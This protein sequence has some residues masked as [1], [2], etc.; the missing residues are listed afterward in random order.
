MGTVKDGYYKWRISGVV[1]LAV[2]VHVD[3]LHPDPASQ[4]TGSR[5]IHLPDLE[6]FFRKK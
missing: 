2:Y 1:F 5:Y 3:N 4:S 6:F